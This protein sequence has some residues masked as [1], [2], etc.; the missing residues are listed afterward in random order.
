MKGNTKHLN[1]GRIVDLSVPLTSMR[2]PVYPG[3]PQPVRTTFST[4]D[5]TGFRSNLWVFEE[6]SATHVDAPAHVVPD[7]STIDSIPLS[8]Y[9]GRGVVLNFA[10]FRPKSEIGRSDV[11]KRLREEGVASGRLPDTILLFYTGYTRRFG[12][13]SWLDNPVLNKEAC[14]FVAGL[15]VKA[16]G[17]DAASPDREPY[18]AHK[19]LLP[20]GIS[21][22]ENLTNLERL[23]H[24]TFTFVGAPLALSGG[25][26]GL[27]RAFAVV[28]GDI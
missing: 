27:V 15:Q 6:H 16:I 28:D 21:I 4:I 9:V 8:R 2:S 3:S 1:E 18:P 5:E 14:E 13:S 26:G 7:R 12:T 20:A 19:V 22:Y 10:R 17:F 24:R 11:V 23:L 25:T